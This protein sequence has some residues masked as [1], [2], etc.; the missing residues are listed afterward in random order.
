MSDTPRTDAVVLSDQIVRES[1]L[2]GADRYADAV[3]IARQLEREL[4][5]RAV[6]MNMVADGLEEAIAYA[7]K[8]GEKHTNDH[9]IGYMQSAV[10]SW[11]PRLRAALRC[12]EGGGRVRDLDKCP[13]CGGPA[14]NGHDRCYPPNPYYCTKCNDAPWPEPSPEVEENP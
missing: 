10:G 2:L 5:T 4:I 1:R 8:L 7:T 6:E 11:V 13:K 14:D 3:A 12:A 9:A